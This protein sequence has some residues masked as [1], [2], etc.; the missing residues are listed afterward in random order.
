[1]IRMRDD[2][3]EIIRRVL[4]GDAEAYGDLVRRHS[5]TLLRLTLRITGNPSDAEEAVQEAFLLA[6]RKL[7]SFQFR[8]SFGTWVYRIAVR[9]ALDQVHRRAP[10]DE[11]RV[12]YADAPDLGEIQVADTAAGPDRLLLSAEMAR[13]GEDALHALTA[14][15]R[16]AFVLRH[17]EERT[18]Q[19]IADVLHI[20]PNAAKQA[21][22]RAVQK[23]RLRLA[24]LQVIR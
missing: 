23:L 7:G 24:S 22:F 21:V 3:R 17:M 20:A 16:T 8:A 19:E 11:A 9:C 18:T 5:P 14:L 13:L 12:G 1:M 2:E 6:Y 4:S 15:E 10:L